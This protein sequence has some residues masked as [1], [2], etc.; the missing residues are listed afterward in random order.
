MTN[1][2]ASSPL[3]LAA[4]RRKFDWLE[5][6]LVF[7]AAGVRFVRLDLVSITADEGI[8]VLAATQIT[9]LDPRVWPL[10]GLPSVGIHNSAL[11]MYLLAIPN[12][13]F[14]HPLSGVV[15]IIGFDLITLIL[16]FRLADRVFGRVAAVTTGVL[17]ATAPWIVFYARQMWPPS[18]V[19]LATISVVGIGLHWLRNRKPRDL[20]LL[21]F[22]TCLLPQIH[23]SG[24]CAPVWFVI[25]LAAGRGWK[26]PLPLATGL[27]LG[28]ATW[29]PWI[30]FQHLGDWEEV[31]WAVGGVGG[32]APITAT[33]WAASRYWQTLLHSGGFEYWFA[34]APHELPEDF[35]TPILLACRITALVLVGLAVIA[36]IWASCSGPTTRLLALW[37]VLPILMLTLV[38][39]IVHPHYVLIAFPVPFILIGGMVNRL[40]VFVGPLRLAT[41]SIAMLGIATCHLRFVSGWLQFIA[42]GRPDGRGQFQLSYHQRRQAIQ[43]I[44]EDSPDRITGLM[45]AFAGQQPAYALI[46]EYEQ[47]RRGY[48]R[49]PTDASRQYWVDESPETSFDPPEGWTAERF[50]RVGPTRIIRLRHAGKTLERPN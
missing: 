21:A 7:L 20:T 16:A 22:L 25:V 39:P 46:L 3:S 33:V 9:L 37:A 48:M 35:P 11:F 26:T 42:A 30:V 10:A 13:V 43:S 28:L 12:F 19:P 40:V 18:C 50:W 6:F 17:W 2:S 29:T 24:F 34:V 27:L 1:D 4:G 31:R 15:L 41:I 45:G 44:L 49:F 8:H 23:F 14:R 5:M 36:L 47:R 38:R 32:R